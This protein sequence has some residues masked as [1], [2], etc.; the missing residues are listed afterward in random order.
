M[1]SVM[2]C[3]SWLLSP[4]LLSPR[5]L[6]LISF[7]FF[8]SVLYVIYIK[9]NSLSIGTSTNVTSQIIDET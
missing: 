6:Y 9:R 2:I 3:F 1:Y 4:C 7:D 8:Y 5:V